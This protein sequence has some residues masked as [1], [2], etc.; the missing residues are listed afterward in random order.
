MCRLILHSLRHV[1]K[2]SKPWWSLG[3]K[4][5][6]MPN[7]MFTLQFT[8]QFTL[9]FTKGCAQSATRAQARASALVVAESQGMAHAQPFVHPGVQHLP[10]NAPFSSPSSSPLCAQEAERDLKRVPKREQVPWWW[11]GTKERRLPNLAS[12][13]GAFRICPKTIAP[14]QVTRW[15]GS[16]LNLDLPPNIA[17]LQVLP[18]GGGDLSG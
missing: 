2:L 16:G 1:Y 3:A 13:I 11:P 15:L 4:E 6:H 8:L 12:C 9:H 10:P 7:L 17:L 18:V 14:L 5:E